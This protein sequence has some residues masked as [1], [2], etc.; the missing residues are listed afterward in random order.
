[1]QAEVGVPTF[2]PGQAHK[3][4]FYVWDRTDG[5]YMAFMPSGGTVNSAVYGFYKPIDDTDLSPIFKE[6]APRATWEA[7][8]YPN[9]PIGHTYWVGRENG[10]ARMIADCFTI[11]KDNGTNSWCV[12]VETPE[13]AVWMNENP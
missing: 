12:S 13:I 4:T 10:I 5:F 3:E 8:A 6:T 7:F 1:M 2:G 9:S 11:I